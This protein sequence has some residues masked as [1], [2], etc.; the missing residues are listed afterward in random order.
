MTCDTL[1]L[2]VRSAEDLE[3]LSRVFQV[4]DDEPVPETPFELKGARVAFV[5]THVWPKAG[6]GTKGAW[7]KAQEL[8]KKKGANVEEMKLPGEFEDIKRWH[9][10]VLSGE[11]RT[12]FLGR[13]NLLPWLLWLVY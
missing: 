8:L 5:M 6:N 3:L 13:L 10:D 12:S 7:T 9:A 4:V 11:G 2:Y 1:G